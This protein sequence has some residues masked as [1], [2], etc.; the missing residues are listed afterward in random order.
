MMDM[1]SSSMSMDMASSTASAS[2][3]MDHHS[4]SMSMPMS[5]STSSS[6]SGMDSMD[7]M[8][9][10]MSMN[11]FL[12]TKYS[13]YPVIF[14]TLKASNGASAF[15]I[16]CILFFTAF[17]T[18]GLTFL[19]AYLQQKVFTPP[20]KFDLSENHN[21]TTT[22]NKSDINESSNTVDTESNESH[23]QKH[24][25][26][27]SVLAQ[28]LDITPTSI[29]RDFIRLLLAFLSA[30]FGY[31]LMLAAMTFII[32]YFFAII[33]GLSFGEVFFFRLASIMEI[34]QSESFCE[35]FH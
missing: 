23:T 1:G 33:L 28:F 32:P 12:T 13:G 11:T 2:M 17:A 24:L 15:G 10:D 21:H 8:D 31:A 4:M 18:R 35:S 25:K 27:R 14:Q 29:Y 6:M 20:K 19:G 30:M 22:I 5:S 26:N 9:M 16:F 7:G 34:N 3:S